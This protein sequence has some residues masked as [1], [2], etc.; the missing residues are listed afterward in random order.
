MTPGN[1]RELG[2]QQLVTYCLNDMERV[3]KCGTR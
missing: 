3:R 2:V 1:M